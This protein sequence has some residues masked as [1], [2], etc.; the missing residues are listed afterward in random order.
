LLSPISGYNLIRT[1]VALE[2]LAQPVM[3]RLRHILEIRTDAILP[4]LFIL[5][6]DSA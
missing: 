4:F 3:Q 1:D 5:N 6:D 2:I